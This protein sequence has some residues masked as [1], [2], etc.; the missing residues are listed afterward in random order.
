MG[1]GQQGEPH[2]G[3]RTINWQCTPSTSSQ[4]LPSWLYKQLSQ[5]KKNSQNVLREESIANLTA[6][7]LVSPPPPP[8]HPPRTQV[9]ALVAIVLA[10]LQ[11]ASRQRDLSYEWAT[12]EQ[13]TS[14]FGAGMKDKK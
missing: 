3:A 11:K 14:H 12:H 2:F 7:M 4:L 8:S 6:V 10:S 1:R 9:A 13:G 5:S